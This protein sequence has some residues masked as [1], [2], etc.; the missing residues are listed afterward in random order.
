MISAA[1]SWVSEHGKEGLI[2]R[3]IVTEGS[4]C[5]IL[6]PRT[7]KV[8]VGCEPTG[9]LHSFPRIPAM[10]CEGCFLICAAQRGGA[11]A[12]T[13]PEDVRLRVYFALW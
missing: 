9:F 1:G 5:A 11:L 3:M 12:F 2:A 13:V 6:H 7:R 8:L 10:H 4:C